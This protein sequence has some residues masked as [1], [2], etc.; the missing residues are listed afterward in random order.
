MK[1]KSNSKANARFLREVCK[2]GALAI[3]ALFAFTVIPTMA[4]DPSLLLCLGALLP[5]MPVGKRGLFFDK[6]DDGKGAQWSEDDLADM[7]EGKFRAKVLSAASAA[8]EQMKTIKG[9][10]DTK[11]DDWQKENKKAVQELTALKGQVTDVQELSKSLKKVMDARER[12]Y[13]LATASLSPIRRV[14]SDPVKR[15]TLNLIVRMACGR[16]GDLSGAVEVLRKDLDSGNTPGSTLVNA[17]LLPEVYDTLATY[18]IWNTLGVRRL[19]T[20]TTNMPVKTVR[21]LALWVDEAA[22]IDVDATKAGTTTPATVKKAGALLSISRELLQDAEF[23]VT[24]DVLSDFAEAIAYRLDYSFFAG[25][26]TADNLN[27]GYTGV[28]NAGT[29]AVAADGNTSVEALDFEDFVRCLTSVAPVVLSRMARW[30][31]HPT[32]IAR[33]LTVKDGNGRPIFLTALEAPTYGGL[34]SILGYPVTPGHALPSTNAAGS[35]VAAFGD[36]Q[37]YVVGIRQDIEFASSDHY[38]FNTDERAFRGVARAAGKI[39]RQDAF[40]IL[41]L[42]AA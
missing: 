16:E 29:A 42:P 26:G 30:W 28:L 33:A 11:V 24:A 2:L 39:R 40:A 41:T 38:A 9:E 27:G 20:K 35:K 12:E 17:Q 21:A 14:M 1:Y 22:A 10:I 18:G 8:S 5:V 36:P 13:H 25:D 3:L 6:A 23:D 7:P 15:A 34:G 19:G 31:M 32:T 37:G 4:Q